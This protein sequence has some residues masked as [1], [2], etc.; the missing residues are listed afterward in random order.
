[1]ADYT[2]SKATSQGTYPI[3]VKAYSNLISRVESFLTPEHFKSRYLKGIDVSDYTDEE[4]KDEIMLATNEFELMSGLT[5]NKVQ[6]T[7]A[8]PFDHSLYRSFVYVKTNHGPILSVEKFDI[9]ASNEETIYPLP[10]EWLDLRLGHRRQINIVPLLTATSVSGANTSLS[11]VNPTGAYLFAYNLGG[12]RW[13]PTFWRI[14]YTSGLCKEEGKIPIIVNQ[15]I[16]M[17][18]AIEVL[19]SKA[20]QIKYTSQ[21]LG[22]D[23]LSQS[24][25]GLGPHT[26]QARIEELQIKKDKLMAKIKAIFTSKYYL[27]NI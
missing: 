3:E 19:S 20:A 5:V 27:S 1:M 25:G 13:M 14:T 18:A 8:I 10:I 15:V 23:G 22:Q 2:N 6:H 17:I 24:S 21:S 26:Y 9:E 12:I 4:L 7:E 16:G 11:G